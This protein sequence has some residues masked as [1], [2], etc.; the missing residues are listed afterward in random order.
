MG[1]I[2]FGLLTSVWCL[3]LHFSLELERQWVSKGA[4]YYEIYAL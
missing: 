1:D 3:A 2:V 4:L